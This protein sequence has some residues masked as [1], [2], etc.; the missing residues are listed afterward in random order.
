MCRPVHSEV[1]ME[2]ES[3]NDYRTAVT[4]V[5]RMSYVLEVCR[6]GDTAPE[7]E[8]VIAFEDLLRAIV[9]CPITEQES[10]AAESEVLPMRIGDRTDDSGNAAF[11]ARPS[12]PVAAERCPKC[13][14][15]VH[16]RVRKRFVLT[17]V[18]SG[19]PKGHEIIRDWLL[20]VHAEAV[21]AIA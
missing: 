7:V 12:P 5:A 8:R 4:V 2:A 3:G 11:V 1:R 6:H 15:S 17:F 20:D 14:G 10:L 19:A 21:F 16:L 9:E 13:A 18:P